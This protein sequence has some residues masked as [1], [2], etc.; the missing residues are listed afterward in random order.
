MV[1]H[2]VGPRIDKPKTTDTTDGLVKE[3]NK[4]LVLRMNDNDLVTDAEV[5]RAGRG[6]GAVYRGWLG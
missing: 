6:V 5:Y 1:T 3:R 4:S 2:Q